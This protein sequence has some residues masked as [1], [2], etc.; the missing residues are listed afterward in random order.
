M[1]TAG[2]STENAVY[3]S[4]KCKRVC[5]LYAELYTALVRDPLFFKGSK[6][7]PRNLL[8]SLYLRF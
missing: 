4:V 6:R 2:A 3:K 1:T 5:K 8:I 7:D